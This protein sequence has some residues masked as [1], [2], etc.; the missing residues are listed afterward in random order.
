MKLW[1]WEKGRSI[2]TQYWK[3]TLW[4]FR[5]WKWGFD[6]YIL[7]YSPKVLLKAHT[8][9][10][11][12]GKHYRLNIKLWGQAYFSIF[13]KEK[14]ITMQNRFIAFRPDL[15]KHML[16]VGPKGCIK[17]SFGFVKYK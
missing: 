1:K 10:V 3:F 12:N 16:L 2:G 17:L 4:Y 7:K 14:W 15:Y 13:K 11:E 5:I 8:D 6:A 9:P